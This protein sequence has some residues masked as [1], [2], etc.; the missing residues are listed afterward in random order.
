MEALFVEKQ[1]SVLCA[2]A[3]TNAERLGQGASAAAIAIMQSEADKFCDLTAPVDKGAL[4]LAYTRRMGLSVRLTAI[5]RAD[6]MAEAY[7]GAADKIFQE[8]EKFCQAS[9]PMG[10][11]DYLDH[12][13]QNL[14]LTS[15][16]ADLCRQ[17]S[18]LT[19]GF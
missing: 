12:Q 2:S 16:L 13:L 6:A 14:A 15:K 1:W 18:G 17:V 7:P 10:D 4:H 5:S 9:L 19:P 8:V 11:D 3:R